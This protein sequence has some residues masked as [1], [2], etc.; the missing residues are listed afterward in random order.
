MKKSSTY[1]RINGLSW[2]VLLVLSVHQ[3]VV[4]STRSEQSFG[5]LV[6][7]IL[8]MDMVRRTQAAD[9]EVRMDELDKDIKRLE[10]E[11]ADVRSTRHP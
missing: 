9:A 10:R 4:G 5:L 2:I 6:C 1:D 8:V 3:V 11:L 7:F